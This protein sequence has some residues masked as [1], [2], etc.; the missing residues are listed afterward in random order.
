MSVM[1]L[2]SRLLPLL[3]LVVV[4]LAAGSSATVAATGVIDGTGTSYRLTIANTG[5]EPIKC[6]RLTVPAGVTIT[7]FGAPPAGWQLGS[8]GPLPQPV[9]GGRN[10]AGIAPGQSA[11]FPFTT[12]VAIPPNPGALSNRTS[13]ANAAAITSTL[14]VSATCLAGSDVLAVLQGPGGGGGAKCQCTKLTVKID[15]NLLKKKALPP[16]KQDFGVGFTWTMTCN[17]GAGGCTGRVDFLPPKILAGSL[18]KPKGNLH[19]NITRKTISCAGPCNA[20]TTGRF[21][22]KMKSTAQLNQLFGRTMAYQVRLWCIVDGQPVS[23]GAVTIKVRVDQKG[24]LR[25][26]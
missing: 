9:I 14:L 17:A 23:Q 21:E 4:P 7:A 3:A 16:D 1:R 8:P 10:D 15:G 20:A 12:N 5:T 6:W 24:T 2:A 22:I 25:S 13:G 26:P 11:S 19:L 18:P